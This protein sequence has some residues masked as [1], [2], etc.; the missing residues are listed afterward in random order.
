[1]LD[2]QEECSLLKLNQG[3]KLRCHQCRTLMHQAIEALRVAL[4]QDSSLNLLHHQCQWVNSNLHKPKLCHH[5]N[6]NQMPLLQWAEELPG[7]WLQAW[8]HPD[9]PVHQLRVAHPMR[10]QTLTLK[11]WLET[12][13]QSCNSTGKLSKMKSRRQI[14][15]PRSIYWLTG[16]METSFIQPHCKSF[17]IF[18]AWLIRAITKVR[19]LL[20]ENWPKSAGETSRTSPMLWRSSLHSSRNTTSDILL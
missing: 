17:K 19:L 7:P 15:G 13:A 4:H 9:P 12:S 14:Q 8:L 11:L 5:H 1:M 6:S 10:D 18:Q 2:H 20:S 16:W 3:D